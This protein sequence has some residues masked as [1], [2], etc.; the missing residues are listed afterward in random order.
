MD[1]FPPSCFCLLDETEWE[2]LVD[3]SSRDSYQPHLSRFLRATGQSRL[4]RRMALS[5]SAKPF[6][7]PHVEIDGHGWIVDKAGTCRGRLVRLSLPAR[8]YEPQLA[9]SHDWFWSE[10]CSFLCSATCWAQI[11]HGEVD[12]VLSRRHEA[13]DRIEEQGITRW[14]KERWEQCWQHLGS[15]AH[16]EQSLALYLEHKTLF[17]K[18]AS[19][20]GVK[21]IPVFSRDLA[22]FLVEYYKNGPHRLKLFKKVTLPAK[23]HELEEL[24][25]RGTFTSIPFPFNETEHTAVP[26]GDCFL[27]RSN[28]VACHSCGRAIARRESYPRLALFLKDADERPQSGKHKDEKP[29]FCPL[30]VAMVLVCPVKLTPETLTVRFLS[31]DEDSTV[32]TTATEELRKYVAQ[33]LHVHAGNFVSLHVPERA[34]GKFLAALWGAQAYSLWKMAVTFPPELFQRGFGVEVFPGEEQFRLPRWLLWFTSAL[35]HWHHGFEYRCYAVNE[36]RVPFAQFLRL[37]ARGKVFHAFYTLMAGGVIQ[38]DSRSW[39]WI[40]LQDIWAQL[41]TLM[42]EEDVMPLPD[43]PTIVGFAGL[44]LPLAERVEYRKRSNPKEAKRA[45]GK[46]LEEVDRPIQYA[47]T[48]AREAGDSTFIFCRRAQ[49]R[50]FYDKAVELLDRAGEDVES[51]RR[52]GRRIVEEREAFAWARDAEE[53]I[54]IG[55]DQVVRV[56]CYLVNEGEAPPYAAEADWRAFAYQVKLALWSMFPH[57]LGT[58]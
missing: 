16:L 50:T 30:C 47:Y 49:Y 51:L 5:A 18:Q 39:R 42:Q 35:A 27:G 46:L 56:A 32:G 31:S 55:P 34:D 52:E 11:R 36:L 28:P 38:E 19:P 8:S 3:S 2:A 48:A 25:D 53:Q 17:K 33:S 20:W 44:L 1:L 45:I 54:F 4:L 10:W 14:L 58:E 41:E 29:L 24:L 57:Y 43:Y 22:E 6:A 40:A 26:P 37:A 13:W 7:F 9:L 12:L 23:T 21:D 15:R